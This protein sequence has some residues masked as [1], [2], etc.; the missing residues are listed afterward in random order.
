MLKFKNNRYLLLLQDKFQRIVTEEH[1][2]LIK[3]GETLAE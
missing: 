3:D 1:P 2:E